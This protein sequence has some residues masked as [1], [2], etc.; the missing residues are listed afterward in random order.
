M[1]KLLLTWVILFLAIGLG[2]AQTEKTVVQTFVP[3]EDCYFAVFALNRPTAVQTWEE[4]TVKIVYTI[5]VDG[6]NEKT[7]TP[8]IEMQFYEEERVIIFEIPNQEENILK[9][10][11]MV[12]DF[13]E[14]EV[15][16]PY[17]IK[18][19]VVPSNLHP[20]L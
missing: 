9:N 5:K 14:V 7:I 20:L 2:W 16:I 13:L 15:F 19:Y 12:G 6:A 18:Y 10:V 8:P 1:K 11:E 17:G 4:P 3:E